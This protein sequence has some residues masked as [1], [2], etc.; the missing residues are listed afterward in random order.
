MSMIP[1]DAFRALR[2][3]P[4]VSAVCFLSLALGI[5]ANT[6]VFSI[7]NSL[8]LQMLPVREPQQLAQMMITPTNWSWTNPLWEQIRDRATI[9]DGVFAYGVTRFNIAQGGQTDFID[10]MWVSGSLFDVLGVTPV[11]GRPL[12]PQDDVRGAGGPDGPAVVISY[13][14]WQ[15]RYGGAPDVLGRTM[16]IERVPFTIVGVAPAGFNGPE[17]GRTF[18][19][20][21]PIGAEPLIRGRDSSLDRRSNWWLTILARLKRGQTLDQAA[22]AWNG[23]KPQMREATL[24]QDWQPRDLEGYLREPLSLRAAATGTSSLRS[25]YT[26][27]LQALMVVVALV[28]L[29]ACA[30]V[31][32]LLLAR[33]TARR[34]ELSIRLALGAS[35]ARLVLQL[36]TESLL[37]AASGALAGLFFAQWGS[38]FLV[39]Q[40][41]TPTTN[42]VLDLSLDGRVLGFTIGVAVLTALIFGTA[43][44]LR[45]TRVE[46]QEALKAEG[47]S[48]LGDR[49]ATL[50]QSLVVAQV[51]LSLILVVAA[52]LFIR[53]F[54]T[55][56]TKDAGFDRRPVLIAVVNAARSRVEPADRPAFYERLRRQIAALPGVQSAA[57]SVVTPISGSTW[58]FRTRVEGG[59]E[60]AE[61]DR[62]SFVNIITPG[63]FGTYSTRIIAGRDFTT[64]DVAG[65]PRVAL[66]NEAFVRKF[67]GDRPPLGLRIDNS[68]AQDGSEPMTEIVGVVQDAAY[69]SLREPIPATMYLSMGQ[70][71]KEPFTSV[72]F[73]I[74]SAGPD[75]AALIRTVSTAMSE[76]DR[77]LALTFRPLATQVNATLIQERL[78]AMLSGFF[79]AL[80]LLLAALGL[81]GV[82]SY[83][84]GR[85]RTEMGIR[86]ALGAQPGR[87]LRLVLSRVALLVGLGI[88]IGCGVSLLLGNYITA[89]L[90]DLA[91][92]DPLT[93]ATAALVLL[94]IGTIAGL[95]PARRAAT[96]D[97]AEVLR[98]S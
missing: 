6:A 32:N 60:L 93:M 30:N 96:L 35:R 87:V 59:L 8:R 50:T 62:S 71:P 17:V 81:Y 26:E 14:A 94:A 88:A 52:G 76:T 89:L 47:R 22:T 58:G 45:S 7:L 29:I 21:V 23:V 56:V 48:V 10:G 16:T 44:A 36:L 42:V 63:W 12:T 43:P 33:A 40:L 78:M 66:V 95:I 69:R 3:A 11:I 28:L 2:A 31:A 84:V 98:D 86:L 97:P 85:R 49:G 39:R 83:A 82:T 34:R 79:G 61:R 37:L 41:S 67:I 65:A 57:A 18:D 19:I 72:N 55:L 91:P 9:V 68:D 75:P 13:R 80:A 46:P 73:S 90:Y 20:V 64:Q 54:G 1:R 70:R 53:T 27:P 15:Q 25:R 51:A 24:P 38:Q 5:G 92:R 77:D 74:R 4:V